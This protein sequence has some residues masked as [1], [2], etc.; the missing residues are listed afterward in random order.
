MRR[1]EFIILLGGV[2][3][4]PHAARAQQP[5][6][7]RRIG[8]LIPFGENDPEVQARLAAFKQ[9]LQDLGWTDGR[10]VR[11][12]YRFTDENTE[13]LRIGAGELVAVAPDVIVVYANP[14]LAVLRQATRVIPIVFAQVSDPVGSGFVPSLA[15]P[16]GNITGF[17]NFEPAIGGK[18][19][20]VLK[21]IAP[22]VRRVAVVHNPDIAANVAFLRAAE[23]AS[24]SLGVTVTAADVH[25]QS[26][27]NRSLHG[28]MAFNSAMFFIGGP[29]I[30]QHLGPL[31]RV[32]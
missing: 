30:H 16:G 29:Q 2:T 13:R 21:E 8:V 5:G 7:V 11:I 3:A 6:K 27:A 23:A 17:H 18:W 26:A 14:A 31:R 32:R 22:G 19:L 1:R 20:D 24:T 4:W 28:E 25:G 10:N 9:R 15:R 12:D